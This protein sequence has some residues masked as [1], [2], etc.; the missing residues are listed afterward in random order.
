MKKFFAAS[1]LCLS[2]MAN[3]ADVTILTTNV[4]ATRGNTTVETRFS[5]DTVMKETFAK[6]E[7]TEA[8][9][10]Y[11][12]VCNNGGYYGPGGYY[13]GR[14]Y[15]GRYPHPGNYNCRSVPQVRYNSILTDKVKIEGMTMNGDEVIY[16][17]AEGDVV[18]G[19]MGKSRVFRVKTFFLSG[20]C[21]LVGKIANGKLT[22]KFKTK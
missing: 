8:I 12:Q 5:V 13:P 19:K 15:P 10:A 11:I 18:C 4:P 9:T 21:E 1:L 17:G 6:V 2:V 20:K 3:A 7:V 22:V 16:Q 14:N